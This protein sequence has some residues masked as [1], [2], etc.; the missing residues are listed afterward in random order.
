MDQHPQ[1]EWDAV[2]YDPRFD[3]YTI[4]SGDGL[5][6]LSYCPFC[7]ERLPESKRDQWFEQLEARGVADP[8]REALPAEYHSDAWWK[9][10]A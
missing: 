7:G 8:W 9:A 5:Q 3:E 10:Q 4:P 2:S 6:Q 1:N